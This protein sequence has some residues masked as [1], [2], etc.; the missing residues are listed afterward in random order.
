MFVVLGGRGGGGR[1]GRP[2]D[3]P[4]SCGNVNFAFRQQ[5]NSCQA[6]KPAGS[7]GP[8]SNSGGPMR[9]PPRSGGNGGGD[10]H[11]PY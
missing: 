6:P 9:G 5:C 2:G 3:W 4:C 1:D 11:R 10:R 8:P 7:D